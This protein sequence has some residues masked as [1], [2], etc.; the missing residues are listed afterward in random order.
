MTASARR[1]LW[2]IIA[3]GFG[4][5]LTWALY[6]RGAPPVDW[7][8]SGDQYSYYHYGSEIAR[9]RGYVGYVTGTATA[10]YPI[11]YPALLGILYFVVLHSPV[12]DNLMLATALFHAVM[13]AASVA[14]VFVVGRA[15]AGVRV[16]LLAAGLLAMFPNIIYQVSS[17][18]L[19]TTFIFLTLV[20]LAIIVTHDWSAGP[21]RAWRLVAFGSAMGAGVLVRPFLAV[22]LIGL[23]AGLTSLRIGWRRVVLGV[24]I[25]IGIV[26]AMSIPWTIR[27]A[28]HLHAFI[29]SST[30]MGDTLCL[31][32]NL[33]ATGGFR[34]AAHDG[35]VDPGL[36]EVERNAGNTKKAIQF[37]L[38]H[39]A[40]EALQIV[41]R[42]RIMFAD[43]ND[44]IQ[45]VQTLG[46][47]PV[48][49]ERIIDVAKP[50]ADW[51]FY[52]VVALALAGLPSFWE[53]RNRP[54][55]W[56]VLSGLVG[57]LVI[58]LLLWG[59]PRFH[60]PLAPFMVLCAAM[61]LDRA[62]SA[63]RSARLDR[64]RPCPDSPRGTRL[65]R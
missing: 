50:V 30:N 36:P 6:A 8:V 15:L 53:R 49:S 40:R 41:R 57:L 44:G 43:D 35:C 12:P 56:L 52:A 31:D 19:E 39:P 1:T 64:F 20:T 22:L 5:R 65:R 54:Q 61:A 46:T 38:R 23:A 48:L 9:G 24:V 25:P 11:G 16:G 32:R 63:A 34:F 4:L 14:L 17:V 26:I 27:N 33:E 10:Y 18:Q 21:P 60:L 37:V 62:W 29:P 55:R 13:G 3:I 58:P 42:A 28:V 59:N 47:G 2:A 51:Y 7:F 45:A